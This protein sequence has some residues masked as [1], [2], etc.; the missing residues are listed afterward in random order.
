MTVKYQSRL[1]ASFSGI[2]YSMI[3]LKRSYLFLELLHFKFQVIVI[4]FQTLSFGIKLTEQY[5]IIELQVSRTLPII[6][7]SFSPRIL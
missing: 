3:Y 1:A 6:L 7:F 2:V 4:R 5:K